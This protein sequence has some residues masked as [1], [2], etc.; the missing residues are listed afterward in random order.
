MSNERSPTVSVV[1][2]VYNV[3]PYVADT[4]RSALGQ[5]L[6]DIEVIVA[7]DG[8]TDNTA[9]FAERA[10][11]H[12][13]RVLRLPH[14]GPVPTL[15]RAIAEAKGRYL[16]ILDGD[17]LWDRDKLARH[18]AVMDECPTS[19]LTFSLS[20]TIDEHG[21]DLGI[22]SRVWQG[23]LPFERL[24][25]DNV[26]YS[27]SA[28]VLRLAVLRAVGGF[29]ESLPAGYDHDL[30]LKIAQHRPGNVRCLPEI[31]LSYRR[32]PGQISRDWR[33]MEA[34]GRQII[35][36]HSVCC[37]ERAVVLE[38]EALCNLYRYLAVLNYEA[39]ETVQGLVL[40]ARSLLASPAV[41][42]KSRRSYLV[43]GALCA[44]AVL[45]TP[46][47]RVLEGLRSRC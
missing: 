25:V 35:A 9:E 41:F 37:G 20:R 18:V 46:I 22:V 29:D 47:F 2:A 27:G 43:A 7:D 24:L 31:L 40:M 15:N 14:R 17:D 39:G 23:P 1:M 45:P 5:T 21:R 6:T 42:A 16:A 28:V 11:D 10:A 32:R 34:C 36:R 19:D 8:S 13:T 44:R 12:R 26:V 30:W 3:A 4:L 33:L 38:R